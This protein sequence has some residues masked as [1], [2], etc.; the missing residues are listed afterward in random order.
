[1]RFIIMVTITIIM[2]VVIVMIII[3]TV[4]MTTTKRRASIRLASHFFKMEQIL[5]WISEFA[6]VSRLA[7]RQQYALFLA[8]PE[9]WK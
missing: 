5:H 2:I 3:T 7:G 1:M 8:S 9:Q 4:S 6:A